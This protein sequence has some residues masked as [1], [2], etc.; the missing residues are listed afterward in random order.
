MLT[1]G[2]SCPDTIVENVLTKILS[3]FPE[4]NPLDEILVGLDKT[5]A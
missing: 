3:Y 5:E 4:A 2:A 1:S